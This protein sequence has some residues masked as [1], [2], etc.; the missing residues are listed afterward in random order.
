MLARGTKF[1]IISLLGVFFIFVFLERTFS[2]FKASDHFLVKEIWI[3]PSLKFINSRE[4]MTFKGRSMFDVDLKAIRRQLQNQYPEVDQLKIIRK[5]PD[6][7]WILARRREPF[8]FI[9]SDR[10]CIVLDEN[11]V[12]LAFAAKPGLN[13]PAINGVQMD[14]KVSLGQP[15]KEEE[16]AVAL[17]IIKTA[18]EEAHFAPYKIALVDVSNLSRINC[19]ISNHVQVILDRERIP[20]KIRKL[21]VLLSEGHIDFTDVQYIDLR[22]REPLLGK[23]QLPTS[24]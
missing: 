12:V 17:D 21:G 19:Q 16:V 11:G 6:K 23:K 1:F 10:R 14:K 22:F 15:F 9:A 7:I 8:A 4:L 5:F 3:S 2:Y 18:Q 13:L 20:Q 24:G